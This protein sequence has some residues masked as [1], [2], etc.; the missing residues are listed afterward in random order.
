MAL[1]SI[2]ANILI[3]AAPPGNRNRILRLR[4]CGHSAQDAY[5]WLMRGCGHSAQDGY[6]WLA[7]L[8]NRGCK[9]RN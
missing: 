2:S 6:V 4:G 1:Q 9:L 7:G 8:N 5:V 3:N